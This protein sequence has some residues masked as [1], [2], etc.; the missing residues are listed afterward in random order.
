MYTRNNKYRK[1]C[2]MEEAEEE[3]KFVRHDEVKCAI[4]RV[5]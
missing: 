2:D 4:H 3:G 1:G 5:N